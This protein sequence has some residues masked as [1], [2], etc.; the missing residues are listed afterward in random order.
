MKLSLNILFGVG[1]GLSTTALIV[2]LVLT[3]SPVRGSYSIIARTERLVVESTTIGNQIHLPSGSVISR[4]DREDFSIDSVDTVLFY[5]GGTT[6]TIERIA[7]DAT[8]IFVES[9]QP[10]EIVSESFRNKQPQALTIELPEPGE[11]SQRGYN[12]VLAFQHLRSFELGGTPDTISSS[13]YLLREGS[14]TLYLRTIF[15]NGYFPAKRQQLDPGDQVQLDGETSPSVGVVVVDDR[16][17]LGVQLRGL[18]TRATVTR[19]MSTGYTVKVHALSRLLLDPSVQ[20]SWALGA[21][22][23]ATFTKLRKWR[24]NKRKMEN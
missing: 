3:I 15:G 22:F 16:P 20:L 21:F 2:A 13:A 1:M 11:F 14:L 19:F 4:L 24:L 23:L 9:D 8:R 7:A 12:Q 5:K 18:A 17:A 6:F 10:L